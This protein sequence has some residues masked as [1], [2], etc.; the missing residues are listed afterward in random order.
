[1]SRQFD[2]GDSTPIPLSTPSFSRNQLPHNQLAEEEVLSSVMRE[3]SL[4]DLIAG[5]LKAADF[6][7]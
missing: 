6:F 4:W 2:H 5:D 3:Q 1:M 7:D